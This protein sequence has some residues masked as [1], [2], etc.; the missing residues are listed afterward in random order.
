MDLLQ[1]ELGALV[2]EGHREEELQ[3]TFFVSVFIAKAAPLESQTLEKTESGERETS[4]LS[5]KIWSEI[6]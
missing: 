6:A 5:R 1:N 4:S 2:T 3:N